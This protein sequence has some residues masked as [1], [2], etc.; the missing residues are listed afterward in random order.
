[1]QGKLAILSEV[2]Y[3]QATLQFLIDGQW[4]ESE[5]EESLPVMNPATGEQISKAPFA[6]KEEVDNAVV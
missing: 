5:S 2:P 3:K 1:V 4:V 6:L